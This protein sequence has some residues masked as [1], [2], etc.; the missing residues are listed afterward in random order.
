VVLSP[1][2]VSNV[3]PDA[4]QAVVRAVTA[5]VTDAVML[6]HVPTPLAQHVSEQWPELVWFNAAAARWFDLGPQHIDDH[7][8]FRVP[9]AGNQ[10][11]WLS[12]TNVLRDRES[13]RAQ[14]PF[15]LPT[16]DVLSLDL[17]VTPLT[18]GGGTRA[19]YWS[20]VAR[21]A[22][23]TSSAGVQAAQ[24][25]RL[26][27]LGLV[28]GSIAHDFANLVHVIGGYTE[29]ALRG[30]SLPEARQ[31][32][33]VVQDTATRAAALAKQLLQFSR[34]QTPEPQALDL[35][36]LLM[37]LTPL[38]ERLA[39]K[40]VTLT[41]AVHPIEA[42]PRVWGHVGQL[43]Q[44][45]INL[46]VNARD[47]Q[48]NGGAAHIAVD[49]LRADGMLLH[50]GVANRPS[51]VVRL[52]VEDDGPGIP[53]ALRNRVLDPFFTTKLNGTGLGLSTV[54]DIVR[55]SGGEVRLGDSARWRGLRV[56]V[57]LPRFDGED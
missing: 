54:S 4:A 51:W 49:V 29:L 38:L 26:E 36:E 23:A 46:I 11:L 20:I 57:L 30:N 42:T 5:E 31:A 27:T 45:L 9:F 39:G 41:S 22:P 1:T 50:A 16:G 47:A 44:V 25:N 17:R 37:R 3:T 33:S 21:E 55:H 24:T 8:W 7:E 43:E 48:L 52:C 34:Q 35:G 28:A 10:Q 2:F 15:V 13:A 40:R 53:P 32:M 18:H 12:L 6:L 14:V 19:R 56:V